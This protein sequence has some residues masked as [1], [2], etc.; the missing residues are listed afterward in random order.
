VPGSRA[1]RVWLAVCAAVL[2]AGCAAPATAGGGQHPAGSSRP[3]SP[4]PAAASCLTAVLR[5]RA[6]REGVNGGAHGD[7]EFTNAGSRP[8]EL[9]GLPRLA[10][11][12]ADGEPLPVRLVQAPNLFI[13]V[14]VLP[15]GRPDAADLVVYWANW[16]GRPPGRLSIRVTLPAGG[17][18][19]GAFNGPPDYNFVPGCRQ[20]GQPSTISVI[21]AYGP[22]PDTPG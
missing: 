16:C 2:L 5:I 11:V 8:C 1:P 3:A 20:H 21:E 9:Q 6:G 22:G 17:V 4:A 7:V 18:V 13:R 19:T 10:I 12:R 14:V 15:P